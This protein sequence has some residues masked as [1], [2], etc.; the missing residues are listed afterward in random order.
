MAH[1]NLSSS[2]RRSPRGGAEHSQM[3]DLLVRL[4]RVELGVS[5]DRWRWSLEGSGEFSVSSIRKALDDIRLPNVSTQTR[6]IKE[7]PIKI[8]VHAWKV[9][10]DCLPTRLN[11]SRRGLAIP[12]ILCPICDGSVESTAHLFFE[13]SLAKATFQKICQWWNLDF[14]EVCSFDDWASWINS[15]RMPSKL[16]SLLQ[17]VCF[18][19]WWRIWFF[20]NKL[21]F[22]TDIPSKAAIFDDVVIFS[23]YWCRYRCKGSFSW[24]EW[25]KNPQLLSL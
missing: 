4:E 7:V 22:G 3:E 20:R 24:V 25:L 14:R 8:N 23:F 16:K 15:I 18:G 13:C 6:W 2:F 17:G 21:I 10:L 19:L 11:I 5:Q 1:V 12:S 9:R